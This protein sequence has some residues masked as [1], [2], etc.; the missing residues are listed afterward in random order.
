[1]PNG[2]V[3]IND[4]KQISGAGAMNLG[5]GFNSVQLSDDWVDFVVT[6]LYNDDKFDLAKKIEDAKDLGK[7]TKVVTV[8]DRTTAGNFDGLI[9]GIS[10]IKVN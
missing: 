5:T 4:A 10:I 2:G 1:M 6:K 9:G 3:I 8:V 7:L